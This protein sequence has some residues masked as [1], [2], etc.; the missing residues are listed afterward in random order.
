LLCYIGVKKYYQKGKKE[1][2]EKKE[3]GSI[4]GKVNTASGDSRGKGRWGEHFSSLLHFR[5][6]VMGEALRMAYSGE[7]KK[8]V[9]PATR[10]QG[11]AGGHLG[12]KGLEKEKKYHLFFRKEEAN[13]LRESIEGEGQFCDE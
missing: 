5:E 13:F 10:G 2:G 11:V 6:R 12:G 7:K 4:G 8:A 3:F 9:R 1:E